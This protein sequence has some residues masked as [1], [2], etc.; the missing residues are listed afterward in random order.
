MG[1]INLG[2]LMS[3]IHSV[4]QDPAFYG[5]DLIERIND[6]VSAIS[7]GIRMPDGLTSPPLPDLY[8]SSI[9]ETT[10]SA[11]VSLP[12]NYQRNV[13]NVYDSSGFRISRY[14]FHKFLNRCSDKALD[15][16]GSVYMVSVKGSKLYYQGIPT[17]AQTLGIHYYRKPVAMA[18]DADEPDGIPEHLCL[19]LIKHYVCKE[20]F[21]EALEDGQDNV[22]QGVKYH[23]AKFYQAMTDLVDFIGIDAT[24]TYYGGDDFE[25]AGACD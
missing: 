4:V 7:A 11:Y 23:T 20:I 8:T 16:S 10:A 1:N 13:F 22:G 25:D 18:T 2:A 3:K 21:G 6:A 9:V 24:P 12:D 14:S 19:P 15:E 5:T 17:A